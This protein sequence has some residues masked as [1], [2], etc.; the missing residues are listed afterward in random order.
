MSLFSALP[1]GYRAGGG[2]Y[3]YIGRIGYWW[4]FVEDGTNFASVRLL[5]YNGGDTGRIDDA[6]K[7]EGFSVRCLRD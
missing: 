5:G 7:E 6:N 3:G 4:S 2:D 1:G